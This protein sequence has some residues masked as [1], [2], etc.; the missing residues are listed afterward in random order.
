M[1]VEVIHLF[2]Q[3][4]LA[5]RFSQPAEVLLL[6]EAARTRSQS[7]SRE[8]LQII[9]TDGVARLDD[10]HTGERRAVFTAIGDVD[11]LYSA[12]VQLTRTPLHLSGVKATPIRSLPPEA[13]NYLLPSRYCPS[14]RFC[15][16]V[17]QQFGALAGGDK[18]QAMLDWL[19]TN[20]DYRRGVS[21]GRSTA[22]DTFTER[23]GVCRDF[24]HLAI[25]FCRAANIPARAVS[26][27]AWK[28]DPPDMH[29]VAEVYVG[30]R[31][32]LI[33]PTGRAP[34][35]GLVRVATGRDAGDIAFMTVFG[36]AELIAQTFAVTELRKRPA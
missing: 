26:A 10:L 22:L 27:Y 36:E 23:A 33:D 3:A 21:D 6:I 34:V 8:E 11:V 35:E 16:F 12:A 25:T 5:Y 20:I 2:V 19:W 32:Q 13:L 14:D 28:L 7:V 17:E 29:A 24:S 18:I 4:S 30:G 15:G 1:C 9:S 31:W